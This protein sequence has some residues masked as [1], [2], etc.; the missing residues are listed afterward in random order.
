MCFDLI[1][2]FP[3]PSLCEKTSVMYDELF[4]YY[5]LLSTVSFHTVPISSRALLKRV[6]V[7]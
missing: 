1:F 4:Y 7:G 2:F 6:S 3:D 5:F